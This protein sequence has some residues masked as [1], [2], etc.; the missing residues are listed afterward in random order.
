MH[1]RVKHFQFDEKKVEKGVEKALKRDSYLVPMITIL[2][3][4]RKA[5]QFCILRN[6]QNRC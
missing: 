3:N 4:L 2:H 6:S 5:A 1:W